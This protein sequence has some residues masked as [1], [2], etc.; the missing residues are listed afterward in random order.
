VDGK[1]IK[2]APMKADSECALRCLALCDRSVKHHDGQQQ[3]DDLTLFYSGTD[4]KFQLKIVLCNVES[5]E[6][7][8]KFACFLILT[9]N[10]GTVNMINFGYFNLAYSKQREF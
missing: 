6:A 1:S 9:K 7:L 10:V 8:D 5:V 3:Y 4:G 2:L